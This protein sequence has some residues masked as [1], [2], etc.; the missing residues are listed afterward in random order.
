MHESKLTLVVQ[1]KLQ[2][3]RLYEVDLRAHPGQA[4]KANVAERGVRDLE[5]ELV[6]GT[7]IQCAISAI[8]L[9][10]IFIVRPKLI[11]LLA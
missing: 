10:A 7:T 9:G 2:S 3:F 1:A 8:R 6:E 11:E 5:L 4:D